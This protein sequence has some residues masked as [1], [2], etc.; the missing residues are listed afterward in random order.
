MAK[1]SV[2]WFNGSVIVCPYSIRGPVAKMAL[3]VA[4][5]PSACEPCDVGRAVRAALMASKVVNPPSKSEVK[6][7]LSCMG[8][9]SWQHLETQAATLAVA[10]RKGV[11]YLTPLRVLDR[12]AHNESGLGGDVHHEVPLDCDDLY[13]GRAV[14]GLLGVG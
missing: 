4:R 8:A 9:D 12:R 7:M 10:V 3:P 2:Y 13:L 6:Y 5:L 1:A 11:V 14:M